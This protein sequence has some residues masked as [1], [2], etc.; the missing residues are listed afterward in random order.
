MRVPMQTTAGSRASAAQSGD[1][2]K[3]VVRPE[4]AYFALSVAI[5]VAGAV[6]GIMLD[7]PSKDFTPKD[8]VSVFAGF[9]IAAQTIERLLE[10][11]APFF[12]R[13]KV[14]TVP[15]PDNGDGADGHGNPAASPA[16]SASAPM[17]GY[18]TKSQVLPVRDR[19]LARCLRD[20]A[21]SH[22]AA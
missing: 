18:V 13:T 6:V 20:P 9:F 15:S 1:T 22:A 11:I 4:G 21:N 3:P 14:D 5:L 17:T 19:A 16:M 2:G 12:G 10:P 8:G 7:D